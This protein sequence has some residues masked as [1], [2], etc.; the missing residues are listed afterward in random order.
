[1]PAQ[2]IDGKTLARQ[3]KDR[4]RD[5]LAQSGLKP[6]LAVV[7]VGDDP[8]S[9]TYVR[10][11][12][13]DCEIVGIYSE[14]H[15]LPETAG[16]DDLLPL[17]DEL[18]SREDIHGILV[19]LPLP[20]GVDEHRVTNAVDPRKDVDGFH[21]Q[22]LGELLR[23]REH[24][25][26]CTPRGIIHLIESTGTQIQGKKAVV[27]GRSVIVGKP[28]A[29][30]LLNRHAVVTICH[31]RTPDLGAETCEADI[32]VV[33]AGRSELVNGEM[34]RPGA[35]VIDVGV[36]VIEGKMVGDV[37]FDSAKEAAGHITPVPGGVGPMTRAMLLKNTVLAAS[38]P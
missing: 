22:N 34:I 38:S 30:L 35:I 1:M 20:D 31:T 29:L 19:Q 8:A 23:G 36:N 16:E 28:T 33:A 11:K 15:H 14:K 4:I 10:L 3:I 7:Q 5:Q 17:I 32:L 18:N 25:V 12:Q 24:L 21:T 27:V 26:A 13:K 9:T 6:G 2:I 37:H